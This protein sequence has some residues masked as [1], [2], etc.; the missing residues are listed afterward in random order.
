MYY[1]SGCDKVPDRNS[2]R[3]MGLFWLTVEGMVHSSSEGIAAGAGASH[4]VA[5]ARKQRE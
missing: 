1:F 4:M 5:P 2:L 3:R